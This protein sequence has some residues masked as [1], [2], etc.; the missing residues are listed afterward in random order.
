[1]KYL[2]EAFEKKLVEYNGIEKKYSGKLFENLVYMLL[3]DTFP[4]FNWKDT[5]ITHDG[6]K[7]F[8]AQKDER[9]YWAECKNYKNKISLQIIAPTLVMAQ[10]CNVDEIYFFSRSE[11]NENV[12]KKLCYYAH[13]NKKKIRFY[14]D[15]ALEQLIFKNKRVLDVFFKEF[16]FS[17]VDFQ[18]EAIPQILYNYLKNPFLN[19]NKN[20]SFI[21][22]SNL[23]V[24]K[25]N[26]I[27][28]LHVCV[29]N[30]NVND[31]T[32]ATIRIDPKCE[33][34]LC[35]ELLEKNMKRSDIVQY[36]YT[37]T[38]APNETFFHSIDLKIITYKSKLTVPKLIV[39]VSTLEYS[40]QKD[41]SWGNLRCSRFQKPQFL[42]S[43]YLDILY[44]IEH[45]MLNQKKLSGILLIG[46]SGTGKSRTL[47]ESLSLFVKYDYKVINF[48]GVEKD[49]GYSIIKEI[50]YILFE[51]S[52][53]LLV[54]SFTIKDVK[55]SFSLALR[56]LY[57]INHNKINIIEIIDTYGEI[58]FERL[59]HGSYALIIDNIQ[60]FDYPLLYFI[61]KMISYGKN[62]NRNNTLFL[63]LSINTDYTC[64]N[65][66]ITKIKALFQQ[67]KNTSVCNMEIFYLNGFC[68]IGS[69]LEFIKQSMGIRNS[70][71]DNLFLKLLD[72]S[73][74]KPFYIESII[75]NLN[76]FK[77]VSFI[78]NEFIIYKPTLF[79]RELADLPD[80]VEGSL[81][82]RWQF[83]ESK[84][85]DK[86]KSIQILAIVH[87]FGECGD[88]LVKKLRLDRS[89]LKEL[90][91]YNFLREE[92]EIN[93][94]KYT[95]AHDLLE[96]FFC[97]YFDDLDNIAYKYLD[98][99][100]YMHLR[101]SYPIIYNLCIL[102]SDIYTTN[103]LE[104]IIKNGSAVG[105]PYKILYNYYKSCI[106]ALLEHYD[107][108]SD[109]NKWYSLCFFSAK[110]I[111]I[112]LG[113][114][115]AHEVL[116]HL[117][118][119]LDN[120]DFE[121]RYF[122]NNFSELLFY[123]GEI[124]Q[125]LTF[126]QE[127]ITLYL[128]YLK[129]YI[130]VKN[131]CL[132]E[133]IQYAITFI[134]NRLSV[135]YKH[136]PGADSRQKQLKYIDQSLNASRTLSNR[137]YL[138]ENC[139]D[140]GSY[141]YCHI[142]YKKKVLA[143]W[144]SCCALIKKYH[145]ELMTLHFIE[146]QIQIALIK[147]Q[148]TN[149]PQLLE[150]GFDYIEHGKYNEQGIYFKRFFNQAKAIYWLLKKE[151]YN[152]VYE[153]LVQ[154]EEALLMLGK[155]NM[156]YIN[157][158]RGK[159]YFYLNDIEHTYEFYKEAYRQSANLTIFYKDEFIDML[160]E[161]MLIKFRQI[162]IDREKFPIDF[163]SKINHK[164]MASQL[165]SMDQQQLLRFMNNY[166]ATTIIQSL[167]GKE[168]FPNI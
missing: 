158:L 87:T 124:K 140:K 98:E 71:Y 45:E 161:D 163:L 74:F 166:K 144:Q 159:L 146:H 56:M 37:K 141:Y 35:F 160:T 25:V 112:R 97:D 55:S 63:A 143:Y 66:E 59:L 54:H 34:I 51:V 38:I 137:Q 49:S 78:E 14:D 102:Y 95:F 82:R 1:M 24:F 139:Y 8:Y 39:N 122:Y 3:E 151:N 99:I 16:H 44:K 13:I 91:K 135:A 67:L 41:I 145:I 104:K 7:D 4:S 5:P 23:P 22:K 26:E 111:K 83:Y 60:Y 81:K 128:Y 32:T 105:V 42:D 101:R 109:K 86:L 53:E 9:L 106:D 150:Y 10:L 69:A 6:S 57:E 40:S 17:Q 43:Y 70:N 142:K 131:K 64:G 155:D 130:D 88:G 61:E 164:L 167:D 73:S 93:T 116:K 62:C 108:F 47:E 76:E 48:I 28:S 31:Y 133:S 168:N 129:K 113:N 117:F 123:Y 107:D 100:G 52:E 103:D 138:A 152:I 12:K 125:Q 68:A 156:T 90:C 162:N 153:S 36:C 46:A 165:F 136:L 147:Q 85:S 84:H 11:I 154:A 132:D 21:F 18:R 121:D 19:Y 119:V 120:C 149:I 50:I 127:V 115:S 118:S 110:Q 114:E 134:Y 126:F 79:I 58:I 33:D 80:N 27:I 94:S 77:S 157:Y 2:Y 148:L 96:K 92:I 89:A 15:I 75:E 30:N 29:I 20:E 65:T 72:K